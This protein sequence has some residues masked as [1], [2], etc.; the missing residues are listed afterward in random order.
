MVQLRVFPTVVLP[1][2]YSSSDRA[3]RRL[4][5]LTGSSLPM[6]CLTDQTGA[7]A[8][9]VGFE[10]GRSL[11]IVYGGQVRESRLAAR[12]NRRRMGAAAKRAPLVAGNESAVP[13]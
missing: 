5:E 4:F 6:Y 9:A 12:R 8:G 13:S 10:H 7:L 11:E 3:R 2:P 1:V